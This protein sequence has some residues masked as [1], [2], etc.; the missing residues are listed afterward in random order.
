MFSASNKL[1]ERAF[2]LFPPI[3]ASKR[4]K[5]AGS[6]PPRLPTPSWFGR[7]I[8][9]WYRVAR[10]AFVATLLSISPIAI[11]L[12][13]PSFFFRA[14]SCE[15]VRRSFLGAVPCRIMSASSRRSSRTAVSFAIAMSS[16]YRVQP[17]GLAAFSL[18]IELIVDRIASIR[19][20]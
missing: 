7:S 3:I 1:I 6:T 2:S 14:I 19:I 15:D 12:I 17:D 5:I 9:S 20:F 13:P 10:I 8:P 16:R 18:L 11:G 4:R